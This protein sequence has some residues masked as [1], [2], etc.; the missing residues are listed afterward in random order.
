MRED[1][2][3]TRCNYIYIYRYIVNFLFLYKKKDISNA[4]RSIAGI[5]FLNNSDVIISYG[6]RESRGHQLHHSTLN[7]NNFFYL[8]FSQ[9]HFIR[10]ATLILALWMLYIHTYIH[11]YIYIYIYIHIHIQLF[12]YHQLEYPFPK[13]LMLRSKLY[14]I[15]YDS[16]HE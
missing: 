11:R 14:D 7:L 15:I 5:D 4:Y 12:E 10:L 9:R 1:R 2:S 6:L 8:P 13:L 16:S 3:I